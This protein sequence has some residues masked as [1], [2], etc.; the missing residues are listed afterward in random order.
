MFFSAKGQELTK[1]AV[2]TNNLEAAEARGGVLVAV[3]ALGA[4]TEVA[5]AGEV[6][7]G[8]VRVALEAVTHPLCTSQ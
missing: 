1:M 5:K 6:D 3:E 4:K 7:K 2:I 8:E